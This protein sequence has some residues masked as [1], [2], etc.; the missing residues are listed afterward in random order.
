V[1]LFTPAA[2]RALLQHSAQ[3]IYKVEI[4][5]DSATSKIKRGTWVYRDFTYLV[6][7]LPTL[8]VSARPTERV[9]EMTGMSIV[10]YNADE[11]FSTL[12]PSGYVDDDSASFARC[13][14]SLG[15]QIEQGEV[16]AVMF[17]GELDDVIENL[18]AGTVELTFTDP[19]SRLRRTDSIGGGVGAFGGMVPTAGVQQ[20]LL[21]NGFVDSIDTVSFNAAIQSERR[22][23]LEL[24]SWRSG[25]SGTMSSM[26]CIKRLFDHVNGMLYWTTTGT[27]GVF[28]LSPAPIAADTTLNRVKTISELKMQRPTGSV[29]NLIY[30]KVNDGAG[31][32]TSLDNAGQSLD[33]RNQ[34]SINIYGQVS[35]ER[36]YE[37][38]Y[39]IGT[40]YGSQRANNAALIA[41][42]M[43]AY[44]PKI[45][46]LRCPIDTMG[47]ELWDFVRV[48][49]SEVGLDVTGFCFS[50]E[51]H[52][53]EAICGFEIYVL[54]GAWGTDNWLKTQSGHVLD[55]TKEIYGAPS[56]VYL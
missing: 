29:V 24:F 52:F 37:W 55:G 9:P 26:D 28:Y 30:V 5:W 42:E 10:L 46:T 45:L 18:D 34:A 11:K 20:I 22:A 35:A 19:L 21:D 32:Y 36:T 2:R 7:D 50:K 12:N 25:E 54:P 6:S 27:I 38:T 33:Q 51:V 3:I 8:R 40:T 4:E 13:K 16:L 56:G 48:I 49:D 43:S 14:V 31:G 1:I 44:P 17:V 15:V 23:G 41:L 39:D 47:I 53:K